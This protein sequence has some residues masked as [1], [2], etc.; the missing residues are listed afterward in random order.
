MKFAVAALIAVVAAKK[1]QSGWREEEDLTEAVKATYPAKTVKAW[2]KGMMEIQHEGQAMEAEFEEEHPHF[3]QDMEKLAHGVAHRYGGEFMEW[4]HSPSVQ[5]VEAHKMAMFAKSNELHNVMSDVMTLY[6]EFTHGGVEAGWAFNKDGSYSEW[7]SNKSARHVFEELYNLA[8]DIRNL[9]ESPM[10]K[11]Q[12]RLERLTLNDKHF[13]K[14]FSMLQDDLDIHTWET[15]GHRIEMLSHEVMSEM[16][17][18]KHFQKIV[19]I[20]TRLHF[21]VESTKVVSDVDIEGYMA[22]W[23]K[24]NF[25]NPFEGMDPMDDFHAEELEELKMN[26]KKIAKKIMKAKIIKKI[27]DKEDEFL[28]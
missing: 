8:K 22:W 12:K 5:A 24:N 4:A 7:M 20:L 18:C 2:M 11:N 10:A 9:A 6:M 23:K 1:R 27:M 15:L 28:I 21:M 25:Q 3:R 19:E 26:K 13:Q 14:M 17:N 16:S